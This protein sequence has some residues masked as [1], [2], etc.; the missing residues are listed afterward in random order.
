[1]LSDAAY[2]SHVRPCPG[3]LGACRSPQKVS[4]NDLMLPQIHARCA[5]NIPR[6]RCRHCQPVWAAAEGA[7]WLWGRAI[8]LSSL[9][10]P[11]AL[12]FASP[13]D[14]LASTLMKFLFP[15]KRRK[16]RQTSSQV[17]WRFALCQN[18]GRHGEARYGERNDVA[19]EAAA[20]AL[21]ETVCA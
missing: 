20:E 14:V 18:A 6:H 13:V 16:P 15:E 7:G 8:A 19:T 10:P 11:S 4:K 1:M 17:K 9:P 21:N 2:S 5:A 12:N 3:D